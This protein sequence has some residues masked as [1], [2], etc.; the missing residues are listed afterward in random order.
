MNKQKTIPVY[1]PLCCLLLHSRLTISS[2]PAGT[3]LKFYTSIKKYVAQMSIVLA[4]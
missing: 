4:I 2:K 3:K 1:W